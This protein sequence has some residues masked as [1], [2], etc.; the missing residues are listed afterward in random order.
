MNLSTGQCRISVGKVQHGRRRFTVRVG[1]RILDD[2]NDG[3]VASPRDHSPT[4]RLAAIE[5]P[6]DKFLVRDH[7][8]RCGGIGERREILAAGEPNPHDVE[9]AG[10]YRV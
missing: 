7:L 4:K 9:I 2:T 6:A 8:Q 5:K 3:V 10:A 1:Y